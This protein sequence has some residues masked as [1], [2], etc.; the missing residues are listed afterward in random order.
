MIGAGGNAFPSGSF[1]LEGDDAVA[2]S[3]SS[4]PS[5]Q[6]SMEIPMRRSITTLLFILVLSSLIQA[7]PASAARVVLLEEG[8]AVPAGAQ[9]RDTGELRFAVLSES[10][11]PVSGA[12][13]RQVTLSP[14]EELY[15]VDLHGEGVRAELEQAARVVRSGTHHALV[16]A[17]AAQSRVLDTLSLCRE[18]ITWIDPVGDG[19]DL[20]MALRKADPA[21][22]TEIVNAVSQ[23]RYSQLVRE[24]SGNIVFWL[25][26][27]LQ[28]TNNRYTHTAG[29]G[30]D[31]D[32]AAAYLQDRFEVAGYTVTRQSFSVSGTVTDN[33]IATK[34][35]TLH[36]DEIVVVGAHY[37]SISEA[38]TSSAPG[39]EDNGSGTAAVLQLAEIFADYDTERTIHF[40]CFSGEEQGLF[41]SQHYVQQAAANDLNVIAA[42]T[43]DMISAWETNYKVI[44]EGDE[45]WESLMALFQSNVTSLAQIASRKDYFS[46]GSDHVPFQQGGIPA[47]L[48]IDWDYGSYDHYHRTTD[49]WQRLDPTLGHRIVKAMAGTLADMTNPTAAAT[50]TPSAPARLSLEQNVPN[51]FN[52]RTLISFETEREGQVSLKIFDLAGR[53]VQTLVDETLGAG[54]HLAQWDGT[55]SEGAAVASGTYLLRMHSGEAVLSRSMTLIR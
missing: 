40:I 48:A 52:P 44:I 53:H 6:R 13:L 12:G 32:I 24:L 25:N 42:L 3:P 35:G 26:G 15:L 31:I 23:S 46:F 47:F 28:S 29:S 54:R 43:M 55:D 50:S 14:G 49:T 37:D 18:R 51:P 45:P 38:P 19:T 9:V 1:V 10:D 33:I 39:A 17:D 16:A 36:P 8:A 22:K 21:V 11:A 5:T 27:T 41:G 2:T 7:D 20:T 30:D 34:V 4:L